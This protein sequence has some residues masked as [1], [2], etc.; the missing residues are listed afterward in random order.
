M[1]I[2][3]GNALELELSRRERFSIELRMFDTALR[4][5]I[6]T[7]SIDAKV[8][9]DSLFVFSNVENWRG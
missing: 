4:R 3:E 2:S 5:L 7:R 9:V 8:C 1:F 6:S